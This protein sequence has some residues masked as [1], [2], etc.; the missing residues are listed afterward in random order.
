MNDHQASEHFTYSRTWEDIHDMLERAERK[1][2][3]HNNYIVITYK[4]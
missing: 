3:K 2:N 1:Q 4:I